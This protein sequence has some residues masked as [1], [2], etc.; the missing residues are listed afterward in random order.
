MRR[1]YLSSLGEEE[2]AQARLRFERMSARRASENALLFLH[3]GIGDL[4]MSLPLLDALRGTTDVRI[5]V[6]VRD[7]ACR[8]L[9]EFAGYIGPFDVRVFRRQSP[10]REGLAMR[11][12]CPKW[13]LAPQACGDWRMPVLAK[14]IGG[15]VSVG[16]KPIRGWVD[17][18]I[19]VPAQDEVR[20]HK[21]P[22][23]LEY[24]R[25]MGIAV[26]SGAIPEIERNGRCVSSTS[27]SETRLSGKRW[28]AFS[29][30]S[31]DKEAHKRWPAVKFVMLGRR[32]LECVPDYGICL[33]GSQ[34]ELPLLR[35]I[36]SGIGSAGE[37]RVLAP[38]DI[39]DS[40]MVMSQMAC[41]V[42]NCNGASHLAAALG[43][44]VVGLYGPTNPGNTGVYSP[45]GVV[46]RSDIPCAPCYGLGFGS[47]CG[48]PVCMDRITVE[49]VFCAV[50][51][52]LTHVSPRVHKVPAW[53][54]A[55]SSIR[56]CI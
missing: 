44:K 10:L 28:I 12:T 13:L 7:S 25:L 24:A 48:N 34:S 22:Y 42:T 19:N 41:I 50:C 36:E 30:G 6:L 37:V 55:S 20:L 26:A 17:F 11:S 8:R 23:Y 5:T 40:L 9:L 3:N 43:C 14:L 46:V 53:Y 15:N 27:I 29:P 16:P 18:D 52:A 1:T 35:E 54:E 31:G 39:A 51:N 49:E 21:T 2:M 33:L 45:K 56:P 38:A 47:G 32:L 4:V